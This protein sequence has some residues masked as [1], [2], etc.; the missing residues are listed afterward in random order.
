M[1]ILF[2][3][4]AIIIG[5]FL[6]VLFLHWTTKMLKVENVS[7]KIAIKISIFEWIIGIIIGVAFGILF[8]IFNVSDTI[9]NIILIILWFIILHKL[10]KKYY[11][12][13]LKKNILICVVL[14]VM[15]VLASLIFTIPFR[16]YIA[17]PFTLNGKSMEPT[18]EEK[19]YFFIKKFDKNFIRGDIVVYQIPEQQNQFLVHRIV[20]L[21]GEKIQIKDDSVYID[22]QKLTET[23]LPKAK[24]IQTK[25][26]NQDIIDIG[27]GYYFVLGDNR[28]KSADSRFFGLVN[29][30]SII[31]KHWFSSPWK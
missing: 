19:E 22:G 28:D 25:S 29:E 18:L 1:M 20:G 17:E 30:K 4:L 5:F 16:S 6:Q 27:Q 13:Q 21:P 8:S 23:Y 31:G 15:V 12:T 11:S 3:T 7:Y 26:N 9:L 14:T 10:L 2:V 24:D